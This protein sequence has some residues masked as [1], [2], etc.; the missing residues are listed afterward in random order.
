MRRFAIEANNGA[1]ALGRTTTDYTR[2]SLIYAQQGLNDREIKERTA[3]TLK[4]ANVTGQ[5][6][7][8]VSEELTAV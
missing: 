6:T 7:E 2:A 1:K 8:T 3:I 4:T 5:A